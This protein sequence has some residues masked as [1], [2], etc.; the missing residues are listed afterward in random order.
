MT[1]IIYL[2]PDPVDVFRRSDHETMANAWGSFAEIKRDTG[3]HVA[4]PLA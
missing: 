2:C 4:H 1:F 3:W